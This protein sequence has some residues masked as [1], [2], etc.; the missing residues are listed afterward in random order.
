MMRSA[1]LY[2]NSKGYFIS[3]RYRCAIHSH[4]QFI[5]ASI[6]CYSLNHLSEGEKDDIQKLAKAKLGSAHGR[7]FIFVNK[8]DIY[9]LTSQIRYAFHCANADS[10]GVAVPDLKM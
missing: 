5:E 1:K 3:P 4:H 8:P 10:L 9:L 6:N 2:H 7:N